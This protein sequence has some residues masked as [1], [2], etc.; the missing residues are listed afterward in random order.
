MVRDIRIPLTRQ[1]QKLLALQLRVPADSVHRSQNLGRSVGT[2]HIANRRLRVKIIQSGNFATLSIAVMYV[3]I[4][5]RNQISFKIAAEA[6]S[7]DRFSP[8]SWHEQ[9]DQQGGRLKLD[10]SIGIDLH[11]SHHF[12]L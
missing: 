8:E 2:L 3:L 9:S 6:A 10:V 7:E 1:S 4:P 11:E 5:A 12:L